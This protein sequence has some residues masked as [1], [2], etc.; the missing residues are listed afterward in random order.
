MTSCSIRLHFPLYLETPSDRQ[1][2][3]LCNVPKCPLHVSVEEIPNIKQSFGAVSQERILST[4]AGFYGHFYNLTLHEMM[5]NDFVIISPK[6]RVDPITR[7]MDRIRHHFDFEFFHLIKGSN[8][9]HKY[10]RY[11]TMT[12]RIATLS[13]LSTA[14][15]F[16]VSE[17]NFYLASGDCQLFDYVF[18]SAEVMMHCSLDINAVRQRKVTMRFVPSYFRSR[19]HR[20]GGNYVTHV[21]CV[22]LPYREVIEPIPASFPTDRVILGYSNAKRCGLGGMNMPHDQFEARLAMSKGI[23]IQQIMPAPTPRHYLRHKIPLDFYRRIP[24]TGED[25]ICTEELEEDKKTHPPN[26]EPMLPMSPDL[27]VFTDDLCSFLDVSEAIGA[28]MD[29]D[30]FERDWIQIMCPESPNL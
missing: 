6:T 11:G 17:F 22:T 1:N 25:L 4:F 9:T 28:S 30:T 14:S 26:V 10:V 24:E 5:G 16:M 3:Q 7:R 18:P 19:A 20:V 27:F 21:P 13:D 15:R 23:S 2:V 29:Y 8:L 12:A